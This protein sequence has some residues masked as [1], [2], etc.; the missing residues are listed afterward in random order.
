M[1]YIRDCCVPRLKIT[2]YEKIDLDLLRT[3]ETLKQITL[4]NLL[5]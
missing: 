3:L 2:T 5:K 1:I 4:L